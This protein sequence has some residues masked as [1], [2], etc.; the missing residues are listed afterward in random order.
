MSKTTLSADNFVIPN[1]LGRGNFKVPNFKR[2]VSRK[3]KKVAK[4]LNST[5]PVE[6]PVIDTRGLAQVLKKYKIYIDDKVQFKEQV[7][8]I[9]EGMGATVHHNQDDTAPR[10]PSTSSVGIY[11]LQPTKVKGK[12]FMS[13]LATKGIMAVSPV[14]LFTCYEKNAHFPPAQFPYHVKSTNAEFGKAPLSELNMEEDENPFGIEAVDYDYLEEHRP[15]KQMRMDKFV[16]IG[17]TK[18]EINDH[19]RK[20][21]ENVNEYENYEETEEEVEDDIQ[22]EISYNRSTRAPKTDKARELKRQQSKKRMMEL[23]QSVEMDAEL[24]GRTKK[25]NNKD[26]PRLSKPNEHGIEP[27]KIWYSEQPL[28]K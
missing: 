5:I 12:K 28:P 24:N 16:T 2:K 27:M 9:A 7:G 6:P 22:R 23:K 10:F 13:Q 20:E 26:I 19:Y 3:T 11:I 15:G 18:T 14:W 8:M 1:T 4:P 17:S 21:Q 25:T